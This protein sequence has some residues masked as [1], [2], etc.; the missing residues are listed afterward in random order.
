MDEIHHGLHHP[1]IASVGLMAVPLPYRKQLQF[2]DERFRRFLHG[3]QNPPL[4]SVSGPQHQ[5]FS[6]LSVG[7][8]HDR[9]RDRQL[10]EG[11]IRLGALVR[12]LWTKS[13]NL[14]SPPLAILNFR[15]R[16]A[17]VFDLRS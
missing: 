1:D 12:A 15:Q 3:V 17:G 6:C 10:L 16:P 8:R 9:E 14:L 11:G 7:R 13:R 5:R 4:R 2:K